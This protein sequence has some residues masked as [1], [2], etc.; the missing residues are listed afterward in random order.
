MTLENLLRVHQLKAEPPDQREFDGLVR[1]AREPTVIALTNATWSFS[2]W[3]IRLVWRQALSASFRY[4]TT[5]A[6]WRSTRVI[7]KLTR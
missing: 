6:T 4:A 3:L 5:S 7:S 2:V 1:A